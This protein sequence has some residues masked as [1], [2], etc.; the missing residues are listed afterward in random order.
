[1][2]TRYEAAVQT[3]EIACE[4]CPHP[5]AAHF[6][7]V[8]TRY[9]PPPEE[10]YNQGKII[11]WPSWSGEPI[12]NAA[13]HGCHARIHCVGEPSYSYPCPCNKDWEVRIDNGNPYE[14]KPDGN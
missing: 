1:M 5:N 8:L 12:P 2:A 14:E 13:Q 9:Y 11:G 6:Q 10:D 4:E 3:A 7:K